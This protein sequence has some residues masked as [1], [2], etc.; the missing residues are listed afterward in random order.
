[1]TL[2]GDGVTD[3]GPAIQTFLNS[4]NTGIFPRCATYRVNSAITL[5]SGKSL[6]GIPSSPTWRGSSPC[7]KIDFRGSTQALLMQ[8][9][10][11]VIYGA[12]TVRDLT[13]DGASATSSAD[14]I[15]ADGSALGANIEGLILENVTITNFP[16]YQIHLEGN[17][18][19]VRLDKVALNNP[20]RAS[21]SELYYG[22]TLGAVNYRS[23]VDIVSSTFAQTASNR[24]AILET[25][26]TSM[27]LTG[28][29][30]AG[31]ST[32]A[33]GV[34]ASG[35]L[36]LTGVHIEGLGT[37]GTN[38]NGVLYTGTLGLQIIGS[39][40]FGWGT[41]VSIGNSSSK[42]SPALNA[43]VD[44]Y[45]GGNL[46]SD[47]RVVD[48]G[49]RYGC[50]IGN[51]GSGSSS[52]AVILDERRTLDGVYDCRTEAAPLKR[53][54]NLP[55]SCVIGDTFYK[56]NGTPGQ[57]LYGC[58]AANTW[59]Q[60]AGG[61]GATGPTGPAGPTGPTGATGAA[62]TGSNVEFSLSGTSTAYNH[63]FGSAHLV[64]Q[65]V[66]A[67]NRP[68]DV[69]SVT[70]TSG[71]ITIATKVAAAVGDVCKLNGSGG[72]GGGDT[73]AADTGILVTTVSGTKYISVDTAVVPTFLEAS[74]SLD[75]GSIAANACSSLTLSLP[76]AATGNRVAAGWPST[77][78]AGLL[79]MM[80]VTAADTVTVTLCK[81][82]TGSVDPASQAFSA[83]IVRSF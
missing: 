13:I 69:Q 2:V 37:V 83:T 75:F 36:S 79:G 26:A 12:G 76:G 67:S 57:N 72:S 3:D 51:L 31:L 68:I 20:A 35:G 56:T 49:Q 11:N 16:R 28:G 1:M 10:T 15:L 66:D 58:T 41:G 4:N 81:I 39:R 23:Q 44:G 33:A 8:P 70:R 47:V 27:S 40:I 45:I 30:L 5:T 64:V 59:T 53:G 18:F 77:L 48:G 61:G 17:V 71:T 62:G 60:Q 52:P 82:T 22:G 9:S 34:C 73:I 43:T 24:C 78:E 50:W 63:S 7:V 46:V 38:G 25:S 32:T 19:V 14:G 80:L 42:T 65:C 29:T 6:V 54:I 55:A 74:A 21:G